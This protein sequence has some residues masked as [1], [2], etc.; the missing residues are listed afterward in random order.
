M[1]NNETI[2][3]STKEELSYANYAIMKGAL[4]MEKAG[5][6]SRGGALRPRL[7]A[8]F[9]LKKTAPHDDFI[10]YCESQMVIL[11]AK[12]QAGNVAP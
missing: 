8:Q 1:S 11:L 12:K 2:V 7:A 3:M 5:L 6:K 4:K 10:A 9:G